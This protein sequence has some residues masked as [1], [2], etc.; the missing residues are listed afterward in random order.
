MSKEVEQAL[1]PSI[2]PKTRDYIKSIIDPALKEMN[3]LIEQQIET[4]LETRRQMQEE[5]STNKAQI[6]SM[7]RMIGLLPKNRAA[8]RDLMNL[9]EKQ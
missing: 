3:T 4:I 8:I 9:L 5:A 6:A 2:P 1:A 7:E